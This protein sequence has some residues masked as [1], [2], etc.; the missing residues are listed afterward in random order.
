MRGEGGG[1]RQRHR[2]KE[3][4]GQ[5]QRQA[6]REAEGGAKTEGQADSKRFQAKLNVLKTVTEKQ[7]R[8]GCTVIG[9]SV[10][11]AGFKLGDTKGRNTT[12]CGRRGAAAVCD[13]GK[14]AK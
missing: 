7:R 4:G 3:T 5:T 12:S 6:Q 1:D 10:T 14:G 8:E 9:R 13:V 11:Q 2:K